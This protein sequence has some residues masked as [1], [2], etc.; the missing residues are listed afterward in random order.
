MIRHAVGGAGRGAECRMGAKNPQL[1]EEFF[2]GER[3]VYAFVRE[4]FHERVKH[5]NSVRRQ[6]Q[7]SGSTGGT[8]VLHA[9]GKS[10]LPAAEERGSS[11][12]KPKAQDSGR[13]PELLESNVGLINDHRQ[14][15][16]DTRLRQDA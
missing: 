11:G 5:L 16:C 2:A 10:L 12:W 1:R 15:A 8:P 9:W 13:M 4:T 3:R 7:P 14:N 6:T